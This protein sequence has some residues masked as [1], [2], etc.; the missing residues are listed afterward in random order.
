MLIYLFVAIWY[1]TFL[2]IIFYRVKTLQ[3]ETVFDWTW[4]IRITFI[5]HL[6]NLK[7]TFLFLAANKLCVQKGCS[8]SP[9][10][11]LTKWFYFTQLFSHIDHQSFM[12][13]LLLFLNDKSNSFYTMFIITM[14]SA[15]VRRSFILRS[16][17]GLLVC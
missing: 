14:Y 7:L 10:V 9:T 17:W 16:F 13:T 15:A 8:N 1:N 3:I 4:N 6:V 11:N 12:Y 5:Q 2:Y